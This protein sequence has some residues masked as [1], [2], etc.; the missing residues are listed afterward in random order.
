MSGYHCS[1]DGLHECNEGSFDDGVDEQWEDKIVRVR[2][3]LDVQKSPS[4]EL[5]SIRVQD[6]RRALMKRDGS[7]SK[8]DDAIGWSW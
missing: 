3:E 2:P 7:T 4:V 8:T 5:L 6:V 1:A